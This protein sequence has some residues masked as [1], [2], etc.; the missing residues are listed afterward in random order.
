MQT[1]NFQKIWWWHALWVVPLLTAGLF[2]FYVFD[3]AVSPFPRCVF[4][5]ATGFHCPGCGSQRAIHHLLH[6]NFGAAFGNNLM[7]MVFLPLLIWHASIWVNNQRSA[8]HKKLVFNG[9]ISAKW[10][11][12]FVL[13]FWVLRNIPA[14]PFVWL[15]PDLPN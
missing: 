7:L 10:V 8:V 1:H 3:P 5:Q 9:L 6:G 14:M 11:L 13:A 4:H 15:A 12:F 2:A